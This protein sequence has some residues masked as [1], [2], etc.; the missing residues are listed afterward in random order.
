[1]SVLRRSLAALLVAVSALTFAA[2]PAGAAVEPLAGT[3]LSGGDISWPNC[4]K[5]MGIPSRR[6]PGN[7]LPL[8]TASFVVI[9]LT[10]GPGWY[11][12]PCLASH[13]AWAK[14]R[15]V[16]T[17]AYSMTTFPTA[18]QRAAYGGSGPFSTT[19]RAGRLRNAGYQQALF[20]V[21][22]MATAGLSVPFVWV[23]VEPYPTHPWPRDVL[24]NRDVIRGVLRA[25]QDNGYRVGFYS[26]DNGW[27]VVVG[28]WRKPAYP[29]WVPVGPV[30]N[31][32]TRASA[33][34][35]APS[36]SGGPVYLAQWV[37]DARDRD[38]TCPALHGRR[39][40]SHPLTA[41][42][43]STYG[44]G[45]SGPR[46]TTL[47]RGMNMRPQ[48][49]TGRF[50]DRTERVLLAFQRIRSFPL[51]GVAT[52]LELTAL[53]AGTVTPGTPSTMSTVFTPY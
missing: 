28:G 23:D 3:R 22:S 39:T 7:P 19:T 29:T 51:T 43:G 14:S 24:G 42:L 11:P 12:N 49:V 10:N 37:Q 40:A 27:R 52:D 20:N 4:P 44:P 53:G 38:V 1:M 5:G 6:S 47:Q 41:L 50:D 33:R 34:C 8:S 30:A 31:G 13:V 32:W 17:S 46:I 36:F 2:L 21:A 48:Y 15:G 16:W 35:S 9:G 45:D 25:Y 18:A 26:Y